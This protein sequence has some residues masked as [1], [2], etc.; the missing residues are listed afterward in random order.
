[1]KLKEFSITGLWGEND[2]SLNLNEDVNVFSG[3][4]GSGKTTVMNIV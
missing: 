2:I 4:N 3:I 1:M